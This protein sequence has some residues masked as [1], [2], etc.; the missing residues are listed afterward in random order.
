MT[1]P[2]YLSHGWMP[3]VLPEV[4]RRIRVADARLA[5][6]LEAAGAHRV[7]RDAD[8]E[9][10]S[11][12]DMAFEAPVAIV[13]VDSRIADTPSRFGQILGRVRAHADVR[14]RTR[15][16]VSTL[17]RHGYDQIDVVRWDRDMPVRLPGLRRVR[18]T[19]LSERFPRD[20]LI[21][22]SRRRRGPTMLEA[23]LADAARRSGLHLQ[24]ARPIV[25]SGTL[26]V[27]LDDHVLRLAIGPANGLV[28]RQADVLVMLHTSQAAAAI[29][30]RVPDLLATG[31]AGLAGWSLER[32][33][34][35]GHPAGGMSRPLVDSTLDFLVDLFRAGMR[36]TGTSL[37]SRVDTL[38]AEARASLPRGDFEAIRDLAA[39]LDDELA[40][41]PRGFSHGDFSP[42]NLL[43][44]GDGLVGV[45]DW[46]QGDSS[47]L[48]LLDALNLQLLDATQPD[49]YR[50][51]PALA[52]Y[53]LPLARHGG[54]DATRRYARAIGVDFS[55]RQLEC[56][57]YA[58][59]LD[60]IS[61][62]LATYVDRARDPLW[63]ERN[64]TSVLP[65]TRSVRR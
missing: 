1:Q 55:A 59:W 7:D 53:L 42:Q 63:I 46:A 8:V 47:G 23:A 57:V 25:S 9:I 4:A 39:D 5:Y 27:L 37:V 29:A 26:V 15:E 35:G 64:V 17:A 52:S 18:S 44:R 22:A 48:P 36:R 50:W 40:R 31:T 32:R 12:D 3:A 41:L 2:A 16:A 11:I 28:D 61:H 13:C 58:Y 20:A 6:T 51:G 34:R 65:A 21:V 62:Q 43:V 10:G 56:L 24:V 45:V 60:R 30:E 14:W 19:R 49:V 33:L 54:N 38:N